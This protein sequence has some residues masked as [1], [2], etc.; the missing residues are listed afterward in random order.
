MVAREAMKQLPRLKRYEILM[1][2][3]HELKQERSRL[4]ELLA[5][6]ACKPIKYALGEIER[7]ISNLYRCK[8][9]KVNVLP[10]EYLSIDWT[11]AG[12]GKELLFVIFPLGIIAG[13]VPFNFPLN[14]AAHKIAPAIAS[15]NC[16]IIKPARSPPHFYVRIS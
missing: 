7:G 2:I 4:A 16:I 3:A 10:S 9:K 11:A 5:L 1:Q 14:L 13:I 8:P 12:L 15:G 6:E